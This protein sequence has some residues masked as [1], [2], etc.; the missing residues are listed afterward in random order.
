MR[1]GVRRVVTTSAA[2]GAWTYS[3]GDWEE[4]DMGIPRVGGSATLLPNGDAIITG[5]AQVRAYPHDAS[6]VLA[7]C[8][9]PDTDRKSGFLPLLVIIA[10]RVHGRRDWWS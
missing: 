7:F 4:E 1:M 2:S 5:G 3:F 9:M 10:D 6:I 8:V